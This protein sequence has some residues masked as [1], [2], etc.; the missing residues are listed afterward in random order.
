MLG[1]FGR[2]KAE[3]PKILIV[4]DEPELVQTI[5]DRLEMYEYRVL[6][7]GNGKEGLEKAIE[8]KPDIVLLDVNMPTMDGFEMLEALRKHPEGAGC[9]VMMVTVRDGKEDI[10]RAEA[11]GIEDYVTKPFELGELVEKI[12]RALEHRKAAVK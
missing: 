9:V 12:E 1:F 11:C 4:E 6:T 3:K 2:K 8:E 5:Q 7:A 10:A